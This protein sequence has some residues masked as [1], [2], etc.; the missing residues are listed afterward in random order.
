MQQNCRS[1]TG[2]TRQQ[3][4]GYIV[5]LAV[6]DKHLL[7]LLRTLQAEKTLVKQEA[8]IWDFC[9]VSMQLNSRLALFCFK[10]QKLFQAM[11]NFPEYKERVDL[12]LDFI[13]YVRDDIL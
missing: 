3:A 8:Y 12:L 7:D 4:L 9:D 2:S 10:E 11:S 5:S 6:L 13:R 1:K